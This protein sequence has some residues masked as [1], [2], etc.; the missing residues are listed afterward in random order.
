MQQATV[1]WIASRLVTEL[2]NSATELFPLETGGVLMGYWVN[3]H[4]AVVQRLIGAGPAARH[5]RRR[6]TPDAAWQRG[7]ISDVYRESGRTCTYL[8]DWHSHPNTSSD[9]LSWID[10]RAI[11]KV[12]SATAARAPTPLMALVFGKPHEWEHT[13]WIGRLSPMFGFN[14]LAL[15]RCRQRLY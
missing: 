1:V 13:I 11:K 7:R 6:F 12:A 4:E 3:E 8:G 15:E 14:R 9:A 10:R 2:K 5:S